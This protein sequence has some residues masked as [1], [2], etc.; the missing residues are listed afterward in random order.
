MSCVQRLPLKLAERRVS[1]SADICT[2]KTQAEENTNYRQRFGGCRTR[3]YVLCGP[4]CLFY[5]L[6][7]Y[8]LHETKV[9][10]NPKAEMMLG[11]GANFNVFSKLSLKETLL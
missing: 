4:G 2:T 10:I 1:L 9:G 5:R 8:Y 3:K 11:M 6:M 7:S